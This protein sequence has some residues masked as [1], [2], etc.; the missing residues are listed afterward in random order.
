M[1]CFTYLCFVPVVLSLRNVTLLVL[2]PAVQKGQHAALLCL[3][4]LEEAP[5]YSVKWYR[6]NH[7]FYRFS[8]TD[9]P[10]NKIFPFDGIHVD[11]SIASVRT[12]DNYIIQGDFF[13]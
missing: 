10:P 8:P 3:Y 13:K 2:P 1:D 11:V 9:S 12:H 7:E 5:L 4:D 6:G